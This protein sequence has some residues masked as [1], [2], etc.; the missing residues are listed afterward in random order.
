MQD[1]YVRQ[2]LLPE[3]GDAGQRRLSEGTAIVGVT[4]SARFAAEYLRRAGV[5][6]VQ[7][8]ERA[9]APAC[10]HAERFSFESTRELGSGAWQALIELRRLLTDQAGVQVTT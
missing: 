6:Q 9:A 3:V 5:G 2:R 8:D 4:E 1:L 7:V 10:P